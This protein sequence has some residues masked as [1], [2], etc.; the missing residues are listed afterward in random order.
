MVTRLDGQVGVNRPLK[1][2][3]ELRKFICLFFE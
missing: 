3:T 1:L 2:F